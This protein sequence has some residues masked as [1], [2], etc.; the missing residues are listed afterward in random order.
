MCSDR[1]PPASPD[2]VH[3]QDDHEYDQE[4]VEQNLCN[5]RRCT[6]DTTKA[7]KGRDKGDY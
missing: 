2:K 4:N 3:D 1:G 7:K 5:A 6:G